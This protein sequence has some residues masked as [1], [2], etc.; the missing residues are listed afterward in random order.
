MI[1]VVVIQSNSQQYL[2][3]VIDPWIFA[4]PEWAYSPLYFP[5]TETV[6]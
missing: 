5:D 1:G 2:P 4:V 3:R 6:L